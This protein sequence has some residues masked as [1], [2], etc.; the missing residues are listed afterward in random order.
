M[1][2]LDSS[3]CLYK[4]PK[5]LQKCLKKLHSSLFPKV[6]ERDTCPI[7]NDDYGSK[8]IFDDDL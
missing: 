3:C 1:S 5:C 2:D 7:L 4:D 8:T 6:R